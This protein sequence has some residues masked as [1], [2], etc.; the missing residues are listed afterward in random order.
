MKLRLLITELKCT[1][2]RTALVF[3]FFC[4]FAASSPATCGWMGYILTCVWIYL[5]TCVADVHVCVDT[6]S[7]Y[8]DTCMGWGGGGTPVGNARRPFRL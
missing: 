8:S 7:C 4:I 1:E 5:H 3:L 2:K 6:L